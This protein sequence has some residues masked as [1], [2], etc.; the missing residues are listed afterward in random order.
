MIAENLLNKDQVESLK[1]EAYEL[2][3]IFISSR[4]TASGN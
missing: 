3:S 2:A 1:N 4:M